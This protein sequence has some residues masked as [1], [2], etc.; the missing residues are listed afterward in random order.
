[1]RSH[2]GFSFVELIV[3]ALIAGLLMVIIF[4]SYD[5]AVL[6]E[7]RS[8]AQQALVTSA[9]LQ[10]R[11]FLRMYEYA[12]TIDKVGGPDS[13]GEHFVLR[14]TQDPC[15]NTKCF[16]LTATA[17]GEQTKDADCERMSINS[18]GVRRSTNRRNEDTTQIC[19]GSSV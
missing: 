9:G 8:L 14:V 16:T 18:N 19:W 5:E 17:V 13:A 2:R 3:V 1:M 12:K 6:A 10:E 15:G 7:R 11:W 4:N